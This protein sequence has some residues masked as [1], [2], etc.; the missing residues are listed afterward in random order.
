M[1]AWYSVD[2]AMGCLWS[3]TGMALAVALALATLKGVPLAANGALAKE[4][5]DHPV[6]INTPGKTVRSQPP[7]AGVARPLPG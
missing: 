3:R 1:E 6:T 2:P 7:L 5:A 4:C